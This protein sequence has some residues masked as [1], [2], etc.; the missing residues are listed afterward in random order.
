M[1]IK[2]ESVLRSYITV[3]VIIF[4]VYILTLLFPLSTLLTTSPA[5]STGLKKAP[6]YLGV[7]ILLLIVM[8]GVT[9]FTPVLPMTFFAQYLPFEDMPLIIDKA[10]VVT[11]YIVYWGSFLFF[12]SRLKRMKKGHLALSYLLLVLVFSLSV[13]GCVSMHLPVPPKSLPPLHNIITL[14]GKNEYIEPTEILVGEQEYGSFE[15]S[16]SPDNQWIVFIVWVDE[17]RSTKVLLR[18]TNLSN[19][20]SF[21][22]ELPEIKDNRRWTDF[23]AEYVMFNIDHDGWTRDS[24]LFFVRDKSRDP[25][26]NLLANK[27]TAKTPAGYVIEYSEQGSPRL[28]KN[29]LL[30]EKNRYYEDKKELLTCSDCPIISYLDY[31]SDPHLRDALDKMSFYTKKGPY[32][33]SLYEDGIKKRK[34]ATVLGESP[35]IQY[36]SLSPNHR[37]IIFVEHHINAGGWS[38]RRDSWP[39]NLIDLKTGKQYL[40]AAGGSSPHW[41]SK[42]KRIFFLDDHTLK[43]VEVS[44]ALKYP[45]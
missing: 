39:L 9:R 23:D 28:I 6:S 30:D 20:L 37:Y 13:K 18:T 7:Y 31:K 44:E 2:P 26:Y 19:G 25:R 15:Y 14:T 33:V 36:L 38:F 3:V 8:T 29:Y 24:R 4:L 35:E 11:C 34:L 41:D 43:S 10:M 1:R 27:E 32:R 21:S 40:V 17:K 42:S 12:L 16:M 22:F 45:R 5:Y